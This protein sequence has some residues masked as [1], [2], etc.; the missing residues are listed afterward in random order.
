MS[1]K[2]EALNNKNAILITYDSPYKPIEDV[3]KSL[4]LELELLKEMSVFPADILVDISRLD[5]SFSDIVH[6]LG[7][8]T[9]SEVGREVAKYDLRIIHIGSSDMVKMGVDGLRQEQYGGH[10][11]VMFSTVEDAIAYVDKQISTDTEASVMKASRKNDPR[12]VVG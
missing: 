5:L 6:G 9:Q 10:D 2:V 4:E 1:V 12:R 8:I 3:M 7:T 11:V